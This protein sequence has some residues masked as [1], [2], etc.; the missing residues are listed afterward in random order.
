MTVPTDGAAPVSY[1]ATTIVNYLAGRFLLEVN[2]G[3]RTTPDWRGVA[4]VKSLTETLDPTMQDNTDYDAGQWASQVKTALAW[5]LEVVLNLGTMYDTGVEHPTH[6]RLRKA[7]TAFDADGFIE[8]RWY[9]RNGRAEAYQGIASITWA[10]AGGEKSDLDSA[11]VTF[12]G[13]GRR[14]EITNPSTT[15]AGPGI[16]SI[17]P[18]TGPVAGGRL[19]TLKGAGFTGATAVTFGGTVATSY[20]VIDS[21]T[22]SAVTPAHAAGAVQATVTTP[23]NTSQPATFTYA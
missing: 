19:V 6:T 21:Q 13:Q 3:T 18:N 10:R 20:Q 7:A 15:V 14:V 22:I 17:L 16:A 1:G 4:G 11:T 9:D 8:A 23:V 12:T 2:L 5:T